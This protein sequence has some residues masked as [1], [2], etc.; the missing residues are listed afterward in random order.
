MSSD[1]RL[2]NGSRPR[3]L[4]RHCAQR[5]SFRFVSPAKVANPASVTL[6]YGRKCS[7][8]CSRSSSFIPA[9]PSS[10]RCLPAGCPTPGVNAEPGRNSSRTCSR[11]ARCCSSLGSSTVPGEIDA[12][13][14]EVAF[15]QLGERRDGLAIAVDHHAPV[16]A[17]DPFGGVAIGGKGCRGESKMAS[18]SYRVSWHVLQPLAAW[19]FT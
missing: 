15:G 4:E 10:R 2:T 1:S 14:L 3:L 17:D 12:G 16:L 8:N 19:V 5:S 6:K 11:P 13:D 18:V 7:E 9:I